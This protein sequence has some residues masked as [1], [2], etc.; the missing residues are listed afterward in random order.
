MYEGVPPLNSD[1][2]VASEIIEN[3][4]ITLLD[5]MCE[6]TPNLTEFCREMR[7]Y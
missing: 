4:I 1:Y 6:A 5:Q 2:L 7:Q 3:S